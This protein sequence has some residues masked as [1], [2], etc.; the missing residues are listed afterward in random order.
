MTCAIPDG[1]ELRFPYSGVRIRPYEVDIRRKARNYAT[2]TFKVSEE[3]GQI[4]GNNTEKMEPVQF[5][6]DGEPVHRFVILDD[7]ITF[8]RNVHKEDEATIQLDD[9]RLVLNSGTIS[10][11]W[12][13]AE[14]SEVISYI[15]NNR[16]DPYG[17]IDYV[18][19]PDSSNKSATLDNIDL[20]SEEISLENFFSLAELKGARIQGTGGLEFDDDTPLEAMEKATSELNYDFWINPEGILYVGIDETY[21][22][23][24]R[25]LDKNSASVRKLDI[26]E[27]RSRVNS[28][29][30]TAPYQ[31]ESWFPGP[32]INAVAQAT[33]KNLD[34]STRP[35]DSTGSKTLEGAEK[36]AE[37]QLIKEI[38]D[39]SSGSVV[40][41]GMASP[42]KEAL[43]KL[44]V[45][46]HFILDE[47][48]FDDCNV[49]VTGGH[50]TVKSVQHRINSRQGWRINA[51]LSLIPT[52][53]ET[54]SFFYDPRDGKRYETIDAYKN[55]QLGELGGVF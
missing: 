55:E 27:S 29:I 17:V 28:V 53:I 37:R 33:A 34:G 39:D 51:E 44:T 31:N 18:L 1:I 11:V 43:G 36:A 2:G 8:Q 3:A 21:G 47:Y 32:A 22:E 20:V 12:Q 30:T 25:L 5:L 23:V 24:V 16:D 15:M 26:I 41:N 7:S 48:A 52:E 54:T 14:L 49:D 50:Y 13:E 35:I 6:V 4:V 42:N 19:F 38:M 45:G 10:K 9:A 46:D 40:F